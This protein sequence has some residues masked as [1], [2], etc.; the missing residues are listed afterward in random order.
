MQGTAGEDSWGQ[1]ICH[2]GLYL[3]KTA[4]LQVKKRN[5]RKRIKK[6][7]NA[8]DKFH[9]ASTKAII[10]SS[11]TRF[12]ANFWHSSFNTLLALNALDLALGSLGSI[13]GLFGLLLIF[14]S[15]FLF[16]SVLD[17]L[18]TGSGAGLGAHASSLFNHIKRNTNDSTLRLNDTSS[19]LLGNFLL[20]K[21]KPSAFTIQAI[22]LPLL[23][24]SKF[25]NPNKPLK[26]SP[27]PNP[28]RVIRWGKDSLTSEI[29]FLC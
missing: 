11:L 7:H 24:V 17:G 15:N 9:S 8:A 28:S 1:F 14:R 10:Q 16:F 29:P 2:S 13:L 22:F 6:N 21:E 4:Q 26:I 23:Y 27:P 19:T 18:L 20:G 12:G 3:R 5:T 25:C